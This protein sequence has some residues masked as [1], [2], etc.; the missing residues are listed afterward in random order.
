MS[1][2]WLFVFEGMRWFAL[3]LIAPGEADD[4]HPSGTRQAERR[5]GG[6][7]ASGGPKRGASSPSAVE[8]GDRLPREDG[9]ASRIGYFVVRWSGTVSRGIRMTS[10]C[11]SLAAK[12]RIATI[13]TMLG[14]KS[15]QTSTVRA[16]NQGSQRNGDSNRVSQALAWVRFASGQPDQPGCPGQYQHDQGRE[17]VPGSVNGGKGHG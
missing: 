14:T 5:R 11:I 8:R 9:Q 1:S 2:G 6:A 17:D 4:R 10:V 13:L 7:W 16:R 3:F 12:A 15:S